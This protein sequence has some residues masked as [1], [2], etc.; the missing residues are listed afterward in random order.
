VHTSRSDEDRLKLMEFMVFLMKKGVCDAFGLNAARLSKFLLSGKWV[1][2]PLFESMLAVRVVTKE[3]ET[4]VPAQ[5]D[6]VH[7]HAAEEVATD[8]VPPTP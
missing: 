1:E 8:V 7:E 6:D 4:Q 5:G 3:A 2:T